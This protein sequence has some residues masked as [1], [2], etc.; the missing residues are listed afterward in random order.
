VASIGHGFDRLLSLRPQEIQ[1]NPL[2]RL[3]GTPIIRHEAQWG[4]VFSPDPP[5]EIIQTKLI[6]RDA[7][8]RLRRFARFWNLY[9]N[10]GRFR[11]S[12]PQLWQDHASPF[13][14]IS[15][16][17]EWLYQRAGRT[18][19]L[20]LEQLAESLWVYLTDVKKRPREILAP[21]MIDDYQRDAARD[22]PKFL[23]PYAPESQW[24]PQRNAPRTTRL[25]RQI[26]HQAN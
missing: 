9:G 5:Y 26:R 4:L 1:V 7:M 8:D 10:S 18:H 16:F 15:A 14:A 19:E 20:A 13:E 22:L 6:E 12:F 23:R 25:Q 2:K 24:R 11:M 17:F 3:R 21:L